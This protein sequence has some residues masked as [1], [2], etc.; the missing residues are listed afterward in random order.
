ADGGGETVSADEQSV[1]I[2]VPNWNGR[3][4]LPGCVRSIERQ[5]LAPL[6]VIV[7]DNGSDDGSLE[8]LR[9]EHPGVRIIE[10]AHN[11]GFAHAANLGIAA[12]RGGLVAL[13]NADVVLEPDW[14]A[15]MVS[16]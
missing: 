2:V 5:Q 9:T 15:R 4:W 10:L 14:I 1:S 11:T 16:A 12:A 8:Y 6:E 3:D 13:L 7:V